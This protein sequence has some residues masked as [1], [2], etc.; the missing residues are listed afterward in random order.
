MTALIERIRQDSLAARRARETDKATFLI[1]LLAAAEKEGKDDGNRPSTDAEVTGTIKKFI[2]SADETLRLLGDKNPEASARSQAELVI[3]N[4]LL[5][6]QAGE[7]EIRTA[8][9]RY[10]AELAE[11][12]P[13]QMG[14]VMAKLNA[15]FDGNFDKGLASKLVKEGLAAA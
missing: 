11:R 13:K 9:A 7:D 14:V 4:G 2:K 6:R 15:E 10:V 8:V 1:T 12:T 5:P 3:L